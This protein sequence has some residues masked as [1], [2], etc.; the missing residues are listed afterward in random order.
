[1]NNKSKVLIVGDSFS[2]QQLA[3]RYGWPVLLCEDFNVTNL[4][5]P[6]I[7]Q[8]KILKKIQSVDLVNYD[9]VL[10][11]HTSPNRLHTLTNPLYPLGH[12]YNGSDIIFADAE[13][14]S[15]QLPI[16]QSLVNYY[17]YIF[18]QDY[19]N[20]IHWS[21][22]QQIDQITK[23]TSVIHITNFDWANLYQF[24]NLINF[25]DLWLTNRGEYVHYSESANQIIY[26]QLKKILKELTS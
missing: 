15:D 9:A 21:C 26:H 5:A 19:Y 1:M 23:Q 11:S 20:F 17:K 8:Y 6:G 4:S 10:I 3:G 13:A 14:K 18:D 7:G 22:C 25:Y 2:S 24:S 16:A 12:L